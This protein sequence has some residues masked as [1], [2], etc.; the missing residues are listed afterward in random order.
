[1]ASIYIYIYIYG[2]FCL[3][4]KRTATQNTIDIQLLMVKGE[5]YNLV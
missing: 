5:N 1:M 2:F 3:G 4:Q